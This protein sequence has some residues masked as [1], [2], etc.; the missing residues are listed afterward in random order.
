MLFVLNIVGIFFD[1]SLYHHKICLFGAK[2]GSD[3]TFFIDVK[4]R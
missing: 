4:L 1:L 2:G 3:S